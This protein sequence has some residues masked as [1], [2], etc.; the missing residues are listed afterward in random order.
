[1]HRNRW[2]QSVGAFAL[3]LGL[4]TAV[5][6]YAKPPRVPVT[7]WRHDDKPG[8]LIN[9]DKNGVAIKGH[10]PVAYFKDQKP[11]A[12]K[13]SITATHAGAT[14]RF[15]TEDNRKAFVDDPEKYVPAFGGFCGYGLAD[16]EG[17]LA[18]IDPK[19]FQIVDGKLVLQYN[20]DAAKMFA[21]DLPGNMARAQQNF[22]RLEAERRK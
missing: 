15:A 17:H 3:G 14:Y 5:A 4:M 21:N 20:A 9:L 22:A 11:V 16:G 13:S 12:G 10:D 8:G 1:M 2:L 7:H 18:P 19:S 6:A